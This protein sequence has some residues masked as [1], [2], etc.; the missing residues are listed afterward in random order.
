MV[1]GFSSMHLRLM[2]ALPFAK[3][4]KDLMSTFSLQLSCVSR[5]SLKY[6]NSKIVIAL[7]GGRGG[8]WLSKGEQEYIKDG[9]VRYILILTAS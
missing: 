8:A 4:S 9:W 6:R 7:G 3:I 5:W 1:F 2:Y